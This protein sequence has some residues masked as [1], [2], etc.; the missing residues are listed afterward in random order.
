MAPKSTLLTRVLTKVP[1]NGTSL[2]LEAAVLA[3]SLTRT[4][5]VF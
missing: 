5:N 1:T 3:S 2:L 4:I